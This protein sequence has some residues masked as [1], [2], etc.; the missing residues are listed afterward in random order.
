MRGELRPASGVRPG[1][2]AV[3]TLSRS[4]TFSSGRS[5]LFVGQDLGQ[6]TTVRD[7]EQR[8]NRRPAQIRINEQHSSGVGITQCQRQVDGRQRLTLVRQLRW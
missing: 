3:N 8:M 6:A 5:S 1:R 7:A 2:P 4:D